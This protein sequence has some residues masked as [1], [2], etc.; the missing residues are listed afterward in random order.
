VSIGS[1]APALSG[2]PACLVVQRVA[3]LTWPLPQQDYC[4]PTPSLSTDSSSAGI[5]NAF[6]TLLLPQTVR[7]L[8]ERAG[9]PPDRLMLV[10]GF[11]SSLYLRNRLHEAFGTSM[12]QLLSPPFAYSAVV[13]GAVRHLQK[14]STI[15]ARVS[16]LTYGIRVRAGGACIYM[17]AMLPSPVQLCY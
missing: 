5:S 6:I 1:S 11:G 16:A 13:E 15:A 10:G 17:A 7:G 14:P 2:V 12:G 4:L 3:D 9:S 8:V